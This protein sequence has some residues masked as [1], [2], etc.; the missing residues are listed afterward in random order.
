M[1]YEDQYMLSVY[2]VVLQNIGIET[3]WRKWW[4]SIFLSISTDTLYWRVL[5]VAPLTSI[6]VMYY[7]Q[8]FRRFLKGANIPVPQNWSLVDIWSFTHIAWGCVFG[9]LLPPVYAFMLLALYE[10][11]EVYVLSP[12]AYK[13]FGIVF[14]NEGLANSLADLVFNAIGIAL[15]LYLFG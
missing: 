9:F 5:S 12:I 14:G 1:V 10:P 3:Q 7:L 13:Q 15:A 4:L 8:M 6:K 11:L 2:T